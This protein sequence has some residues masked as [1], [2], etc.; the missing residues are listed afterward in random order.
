[1]YEQPKTSA[2]GRLVW[3]IIS[4][5][6]IAGIV[7][8]ILWFFF[9]R[10]PSSDTTPSKDTGKTSQQTGNTGSS[11]TKNTSGSTSSSTNGSSSNTSTPTSLGAVAEETTPATT[12]ANTGPGDVVTP[13]MIAVAGGIV[14]YQVRL[15]RRFVSETK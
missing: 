1:M 10:E 6:I 14:F 4:L 11:S 2:A 9:W 3:F 15:R 7:W 8:L 13:V 5:L 12:L